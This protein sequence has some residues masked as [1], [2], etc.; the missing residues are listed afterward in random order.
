MILWM[1]HVVELRTFEGA[2]GGGILGAT[3]KLLDVAMCG[4]DDYLVRLVVAS[5]KL[6][7]R[8]MVLP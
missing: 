4:H 1:T 3:Y 6:L 8:F 2:G 5:K 7:L